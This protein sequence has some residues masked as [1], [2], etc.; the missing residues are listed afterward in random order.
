MLA[1]GRALLFLSIINI[2]T[3][4]MIRVLFVCLGNICRSPMAEA[5]FRHQVQAAGLAARI[6]VDSAGTGNW[7]IDSA[8]HPGTLGILA[9]K[10]IAY[11]GQGRQ[12]KREDL[13]IFDYIITMDDENLHNV[14]RL[15]T[16][17]AKV[18]PLLDYAPQ[19]GVREVPDPY[20]DNGFDVVYYL[21]QA[22]TEGLLATIRQEHS[23]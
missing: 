9:A 15:G 11:E 18:T 8:P 7:H 1:N 21:V 23:L 16:G 12:I 3:Q 17:R 14:R 4:I 6:E 10:G 2:Y 22:G 19:V 20:F 13:N 5:V